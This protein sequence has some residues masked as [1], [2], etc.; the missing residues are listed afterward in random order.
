[1]AGVSV[2]ASEQVMISFVQHHGIAYASRLA[3]GYWYFWH[4]FSH[5]FTLAL[6]V[7]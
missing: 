5:F 3:L 2:L 6:L 1:M 7:W 4:L